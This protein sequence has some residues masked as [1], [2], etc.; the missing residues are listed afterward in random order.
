MLIAFLLDID[1][2]RSTR[3]KAEL[4]QVLRRIFISH[5]PPSEKVDGNKALLVSIGERDIT[6][7]YILGSEMINMERELAGSGIV[8]ETSGRS[9]V[10]RVM[11]KPSG[12][13]KEI[14]DRL[15][16]NN[17]RKSTGHLKK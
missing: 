16:Y 3:G 14:L 15:G 9:S 12:R 5:K 8:L 17:W 4:R 10:L 1:M 6:T 11:P 2:L 13:G 7:K